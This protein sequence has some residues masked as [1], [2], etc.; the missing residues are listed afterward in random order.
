MFGWRWVNGKVGIREGG[1]MGQ[2]GK[3]G[4]GLEGQVAGS[5]FADAQ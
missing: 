5:G 3:W 1:G 4:Y 2:T